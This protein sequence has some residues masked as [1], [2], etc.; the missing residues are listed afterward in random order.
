MARH[1]GI[2]DGKLVLEPYVNK[3]LLKGLSMDGLIMDDEDFVKNYSEKSTWVELAKLMDAEKPLLPQLLEK[4]RWEVV[5]LY[6]SAF[7]YSLAR[8]GHV[9][10][11]DSEM[12]KFIKDKVLRINTVGTNVYSFFIMPDQVFLFSMIT[13][14]DREYTVEKCESK[15]SYRVDFENVPKVNF[16]SITMDT[17]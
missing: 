5:K 6:Q 16:D 10:H 12:E 11:S 8:K 3:G 7:T 13:E 9:F 1:S 4:L 15:I 17:I 14:E 2:K